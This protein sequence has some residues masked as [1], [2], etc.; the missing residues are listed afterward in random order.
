MSTAPPERIDFVR[1]GIR[2]IP[3]D[4]AERLRQRI[5]RDLVWYHRLTNRL[6]GMFPRDGATHAMVCTSIQVYQHLIALQQ[7]ADLAG[8]GDPA[9]HDRYDSDRAIGGTHGHVNDWLGDGI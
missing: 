2:Y 4:A 9:T 1:P 6:T 3:A 8:R 5:G 7:L